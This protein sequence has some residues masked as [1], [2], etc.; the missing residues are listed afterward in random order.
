VT[1]RDDVPNVKTENV[2][3]CCLL[4]AIAHLRGAMIDEYGEIVE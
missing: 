2:I 3:M 1:L 4:R